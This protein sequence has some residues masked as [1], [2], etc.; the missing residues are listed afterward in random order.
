VDTAG[1]DYAVA[2]WHSAQRDRRAMP[3]T[4]VGERDRASRLLAKRVRHRFTWGK[5]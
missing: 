4:Y 1:Y 5:S 3:R 2:T